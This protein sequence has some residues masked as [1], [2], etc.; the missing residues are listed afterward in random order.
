[1]LPACSPN[2]EQKLDVIFSCHLLH[3]LPGTSSIFV[4]SEPGVALVP[5]TTNLRTISMTVRLY[6]KGIKKAHVLLFLMG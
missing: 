6:S 4:L 1:M 3:V 2:Q 5:K